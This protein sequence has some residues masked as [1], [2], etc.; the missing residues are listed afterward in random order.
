MTL[1]LDTAPGPS[2]D[3]E[4]IRELLRKAQAELDNGNPYQA[5]A[6]GYRSVSAAIQSVGE[7]RGIILRADW[8]MRRYL[9]VLMDELS[10][11]T[12]CGDYVMSLHAFYYF[13]CDRYESR[14]VQHSLDAG[15]RLIDRLIPLLTAALPTPC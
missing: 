8:E 5:A 4:A 1:P 13:Y 14:Q 12:L 6:K 7:K 15:A 11:N 2:P 10:D 3:A 9:F